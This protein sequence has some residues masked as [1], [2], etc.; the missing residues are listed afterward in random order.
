MKSAIITGTSKGIGMETA[1]VFAR[2]GYKVF[3]TMRNTEGASLKKFIEEESL[4]ISICKMDVDDDDSVNQCINSI[5]Q[6][7]GN[8][9]VLVN[10]AGIELHG[11]IE[12]L[13]MADFKAVMETNY[14]GIIRCVHAV[15]PQMRKQKSGCIINIGSI[16]GKISNTPLGAYCASKYAVEALTEAL[17]QEVKQFNIRVSVVEPGII[18]TQM[19]HDITKHG[20]SNCNQL[21]RF[22]LL[23]SASLKQPTPPSL[24]ADTIFGISE[25][26]SWQLKYPVG[27]DA[28][29]FLQWRASLTD[30]EWTDWNA[31]DDDAWFNAVES[32]FGMKLR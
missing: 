15:L 30:E 23:F 31:Q 8:V 2:A 14:F 22:S 11:S 25:S 7:H 26:N 13:T 19:A 5:I 10:N 21:L 16:A 17:A 18:N 6:D 4:S 27:P 20:S 29:P 32:T 12:E 28:I 1:L 9:D 3:A 24:V